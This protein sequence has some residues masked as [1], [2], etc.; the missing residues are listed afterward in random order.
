MEHY[1][2]ILATKNLPSSELNAL[3]DFYVATNGEHWVYK[4]ADG[5]S[6][7]LHLI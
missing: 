3:N 4:E 7:S 2:Y 6:W 5:S 1:C